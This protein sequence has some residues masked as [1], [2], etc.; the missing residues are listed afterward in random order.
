MPI[1]EDAKEAGHQVMSV[2]KPV[3][4]TMCITLY[5]VNGLREDE[6]EDEESAVQTPAKE[7]SGDSSSEKLE[8]SSL[9]ALFYIGIVTGATFLLVC[10]FKFNMFKLIYAWLLFATTMLLG[11]LGSALLAQFCH[12][13]K[14]PL[15]YVTYLFIMYNFTVVGI[16]TIYW[17]GHGFIKRA[18]LVLMSSFMAWAFSTL[19]E[20]TAWALLAAL[21]LYDLASVLLPYGPLNMLVNETALQSRE[22][23][24]LLYE[25]P[26]PPPAAGQQPTNQ[27][28]R[29][30]TPPN[31]DTI[32]LVDSRR[33]STS[34]APT[35][36]AVRPGSHSESNR[37]AGE[38]TVSRQDDGAGGRSILE[39]EF[40][41]GLEASLKLGLGDFVFYSVLV[42]RASSFNL[43][44][45]VTCFIAIVSG[46]VATLIMLAVYEKALPALPISII[47]GIVMFT[48]TKYGIHDFLVAMFANQI[49][50]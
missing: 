24:G 50:I 48:V 12:I 3:T 44:A 14:I 46:L 18:Y 19:P 42:A 38:V 23:P 17:K 33:S 1:S 22:L 30:P 13:N 25:T 41:D 43:M 11:G 27:P 40:E 7:S 8:K 16:C 20:W 4:I 39:E 32:Q 36:V 10:L 5:L 35:E 31:A 37:A 49:V 34:V 21:A 15:D 2:L 6:D 9:N 28:A 47:L 26:A 45:I 29:N